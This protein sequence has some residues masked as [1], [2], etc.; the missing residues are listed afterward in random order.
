MSKYCLYKMFT[1]EWGKSAQYK[2]LMI[3]IMDVEK[4]LDAPEYKTWFFRYLNQRFSR[5]VMLS[6]EVRRRKGRK[7]TAGL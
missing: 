5:D 7:L 2:K 1:G 3:P 4:A 6:V